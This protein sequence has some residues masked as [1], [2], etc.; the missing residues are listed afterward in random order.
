MD[1]S[2]AGRKGGQSRS[3]RKRAAS[4]KN[5]VAAR[6]RI[7]QP[8]AAPPTSESAA[9]STPTTDTERRLTSATP[10]LFLGTR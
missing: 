10:Q 8:K 9:P 5:L 4:A 6:A 7:N 1:C 2:D 3:E